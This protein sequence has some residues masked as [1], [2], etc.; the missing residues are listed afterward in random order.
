L[1]DTA[2]E[3]GVTE[4]LEPALRRA[5]A[6]VRAGGDLQ[7][8]LT[9]PA[10]PTDKKKKI[11]A[12]VWKSDATPLLLRLLA[13]LIERDR[14]T[15]LP[16]V[17]EAYVELWNAQR[18]IVSAQVLS[19]TPLDAPQQQALA[20]AAKK[21]AGHDVELTA[22][23]DP[24]LLGGVVLRMNGRTYDGS[25]RAQLRALKMRLAPDAAPSNPRV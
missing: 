4:G 18:G 10:L 23:V 22:S 11:A 13:L 9:H 24:A 2:T 17:H 21:L 25:I 6:G 1:L 20:Q 7:R 19:A 16:A 5:G 3:K 12:G 15:L 8:A 14:M